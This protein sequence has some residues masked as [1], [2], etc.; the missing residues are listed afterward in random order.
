MDKNSKTHF[1]ER[2]SSSGR[3]IYPAPGD[4]GGTHRTTKN[5]PASWCDFCSSS[6]PQSRAHFPPLSFLASAVSEL[7]VMRKVHT[8]PHGRPS[9][10]PSNKA[11]LL[12]SPGTSLP[13]TEWRSA[14]LRGGSAPEFGILLFTHL[15]L[16]PASRQPS[17][18]RSPHPILMP[19]VML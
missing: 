11:F 12:Y 18:D 6:Q 10:R 4:I 13:I 9:L 14:A 16:P 15:L 7:L 5:C 8:D 19:G 17:F 1:V 2:E 3:A